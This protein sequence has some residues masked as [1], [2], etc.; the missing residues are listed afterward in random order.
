MKRKSLWKH[1]FVKTLSFFSAETW[2]KWH[3]IN[4]DD[5][6]QTCIN[7][8]IFK[9]LCWNFRQK[10]SNDSF[11]TLSTTISFSIICV[12]K[13]TYAIK[14]KIDSNSSKGSEDS[15]SSKILI[16]CK[17]TV[18][19]QLSTDNDKNLHTKELGTTLKYQSQMGRTGFTSYKEL[20][21]KYDLERKE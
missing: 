7:F 3:E 14:W 1:I 8:K 4:Y 15:H 13:S 11:E 21:T 10:K 20:E 17:R 5:Y 6:I 19:R 16:K 12:E 9:T 2:C 18:F